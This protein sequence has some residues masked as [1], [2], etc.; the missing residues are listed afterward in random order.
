[1]VNINN[2]LKLYKLRFSGN[3]PWESKDEFT[4]VTSRK[5]KG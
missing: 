1:M 5:I 2:I 3:V 4:A